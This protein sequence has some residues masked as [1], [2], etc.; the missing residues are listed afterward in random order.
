MGYSTRCN[1]LKYIHIYIYMYM[2]VYMYIYI[3]IKGASFPPSLL[4]NRNFLLDY[5]LG[6]RAVYG[7]G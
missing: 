2:Y 3:G 1:L 7:L 5:R 4:T 6:F